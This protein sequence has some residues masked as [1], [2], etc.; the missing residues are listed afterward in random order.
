MRA[1]HAINNIYILMSFLNIYLLFFI[2]ISN[3][4]FMIVIHSNFLSAMHGFR[5]ND[6]L[7]PTGYDV[8]VSLR[9]G[10]LQAIFHDGFWKS[11][12]DF[13]IV[14]HSNFV[15]GILSFRNNEALLPTGY[16]VMVS[17]PL[18]VASGVFYD[19]FWKSEHDFLVVIHRNILSV[20]HGFR[21]NVVLLQAG[22]GFLIVIHSNFSYVMHGFRD[23]EV[24]LPTG[25]DV[26]VISPLDCISHRFCWRNLKERPSFIMMVLWH[27]SRI[28]YRFGVIRHFILARNC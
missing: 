14:F 18:G 9:Q 28:S 3:Q 7:L 1:T 6:V 17:S 20:M 5:D 2:N 4:N 11:K 26:I 27:I 8:I 24:L 13:L 23:D 16:D 25:Y 22:Y 12:H 19:G 15:S 10:V 21:D